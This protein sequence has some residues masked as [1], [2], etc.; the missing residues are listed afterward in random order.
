[1]PSRRTAHPVRNPTG[2][3][4]LD[5]AS[6]ALHA[7]FNPALH[8]GPPGAV[9]V[10]HRVQRLHHDAHGQRTHIHAVGQEDHDVVHRVVFVLF[11]LCVSKHAEYCQ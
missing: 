3:A 6:Q 11:Q 9:P 5:L 4:L 10:R 2:H 8:A 7:P 1:M